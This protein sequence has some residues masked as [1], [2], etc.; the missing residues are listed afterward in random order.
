MGRPVKCTAA[1]FR[2]SNTPRGLSLETSYQENTKSCLGCEE[3]AT[4]KEAKGA[5][6]EGRGS[7]GEKIQTK[8]F[9]GTGSWPSKREEAAGEQ[10]GSQGEQ[11]MGSRGKLGH[12]LRKGS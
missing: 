10:Q 1:V 7:M 3:Q 4:P 11:G 12:I 2:K 5:V 9:V 6:G 8:D